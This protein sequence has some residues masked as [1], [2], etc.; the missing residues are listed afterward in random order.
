M[1][2]ADCLSGVF[3]YS[4]VAL[5]HTLG[6]LSLTAT[7]LLANS[8]SVAW[9]AIMHCLLRP[10]AKSKA[11]EPPDVQVSLTAV[12]RH[13]LGLTQLCHALC[14]TAVCRP[15]CASQQCEGGSKFPLLLA[16]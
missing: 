7:L 16:H 8:T 1:A 14:N 9:V 5:L 10:P 12:H 13:M 11:E 3:G 4:W 15:A 2:W 6:G